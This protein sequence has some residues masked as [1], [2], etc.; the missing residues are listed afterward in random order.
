MR[1]DS[2]ALFVVCGLT[3]N[4]FAV[5][6]DTESRPR[7]PRDRL[8][9][10]RRQF[11]T[12][13]DGRVDEKERAKA[14]EAMERPRPANRPSP[15]DREELMKRFDKNENGRLDSN[16]REAIQ[17]FFQSMRGNRNNRSRQRGGAID[18]EVKERPARADRSALLKEFDSDGD[19]RLDRDERAAAIRAY[20]E[21]KTVAVQRGLGV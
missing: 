13:G 5:D 1:V 4:A 14:R 6:E 8:E 10:F 3:A 18:G 2:I 12:N 15:P 21:K 17:R 19:G 20:R 7:N 16:E 11:D 9:Q